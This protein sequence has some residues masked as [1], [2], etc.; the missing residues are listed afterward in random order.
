VRG[1]DSAAKLFASFAP[2]HASR[3][4]GILDESKQKDL[5]LSTSEQSLTVTFRGGSRTFTIAAP[6]PGGAEPYLRDKQDG[7]VYLTGRSLLSD[8]QAAASVLV[9][10]RLHN[11]R[12]EEVDRTVIIRGAVKREFLVAH[13]EDGARFAPAKN[14]DKPDAAAKSWHDQ[15]FGLWPQDVLG[16]DEI[17]SEGTPQ[18]EIRVNYL[19]R[20]RLL[21]WLEIGKVASVTSAKAE[22]QEALFARSEHTLGWIKI[23]H[24]RQNILTD[25]E[26]ILH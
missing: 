21:G 24:E 16:K 12:M 9:E 20:G 17:P 18:T 23:G 22:P 5:G 6:S 7:R 25:A 15:V 10:R 11:F 14:P 1:S 4:L 2:L 8:F 19:A 3:S 26:Q 13:A